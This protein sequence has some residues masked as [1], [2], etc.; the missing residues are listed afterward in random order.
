MNQGKRSRDFSPCLESRLVTA[1]RMMI[2]MVAIAVKAGLTKRQFDDT[3][4]LHP[5]VGEELVTLREKYVPQELQAA[6]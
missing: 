6:E 5:T 3:C 2:Q 4:A 1:Q